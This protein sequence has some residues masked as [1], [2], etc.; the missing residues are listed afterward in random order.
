MPWVLKCVP[1]ENTQVTKLYEFQ[2]KAVV[3]TNEQKISSSNKWV[4]EQIK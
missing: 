4:S 1:F 3:K 2:Q